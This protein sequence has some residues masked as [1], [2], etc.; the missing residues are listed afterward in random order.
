MITKNDPLVEVRYANW[1]SQAIAYI[2]PKDLQ[3][4]AGR[5]TSKT[6]AIHAERFQEALIEMPRSL[7]MFFCNTYENARTNLVP[8]LETGWREFRDWKYGIDYVKGEPPPKYF[9]KPYIPVENWK[10]TIY[11]RDG[12]AIIIGSANE[13]SGLAGNSYQYIGADEV[14]YIGKS[15][16]DIILPALR[17]F[18]MYQHSAYYRGTC[19]TTDLPNLGKGDDPWVLELRKNMN[20]EQAKVAYYCGYFYYQNEMKL[21]NAL[22]NKNK[23][24]VRKL[25][26]ARARLYADWLRVRKNLSY[27][28][29]ASSFTNIDVLTPEV[30][31]DLLNTLGWEEF[32]QSVLSIKGGVEDGEKFYSGLSEDHFYRDGINENYDHSLGLHEEANCNIL[33]YLDPNAELD[34]GIDFGRMLSMVIAQE[35]GKEFRCL[36]NIYKLAPES[37]R[38]M[39]D[40]FIKFF[41]PHKRK[42]LN[43]YYDRSGNQYESSG[44]SWAAELKDCIEIDSSG[45][46]TGWTVNLMSRDQATIYQSE[47]YYFMK[48]VLSGQMEG[49]PKLLIDVYQ[50][51]ELKS[52]LELTKILQKRDKKGSVQIYKNKSSEGLPLFQLP[53][54]S[55]NMGDTFKYLMYRKKWANMAKRK[56]S[57]I[58]TALDGM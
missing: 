40:H 33:R 50:C 23:A 19:F 28:I 52:S 57:V 11:H 14:K 49:L 46:R 47:E 21:A 53:M 9:A 34:C 24:E 56:R 18:N 20:L 41:K 32:K 45:N 44:R 7:Q 30:L 39:G 2:A 37:S 27:F 26:R 38:E 4:I 58:I 29:V 51:R 17:G 5:G 6:T 55:T 43:M 35:R 25:I 12:A 15:K 31:K 8:G 54:N 10:K 42:V 22:K 36:K 13:V 3:V 1:L 16:V 48:N